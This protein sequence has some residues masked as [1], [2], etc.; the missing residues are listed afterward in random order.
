MKRL[1]METEGVSDISPEWRRQELGLYTPLHHQLGSKRR[2]CKRHHISSDTVSEPAQKYSQLTLPQ[3]NKPN[4]RLL[5]GQALTPIGKEHT[6]KTN[7]RLLLSR[8]ES[9][10]LWLPVSHSG[11]KQKAR[12]MKNKDKHLMKRTVAIHQKNQ[13]EN[14]A[15]KISSDERRWDAVNKTIED[16]FQA[17]HRTLGNR[18]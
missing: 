13:N 12:N 5:I 18:N 2:A 3:K 14:Q 4:R 16:S 9:N 7:R 10:F 8:T 6:L 11:V 15:G 17:T 1:T